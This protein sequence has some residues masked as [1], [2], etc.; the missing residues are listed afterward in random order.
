[1]KGRTSRYHGSSSQAGSSECNPKEY[2]TKAPHPIPYQ[3][4]KRNL[5]PSILGYFPKETK[6]LFEPFAGAAA[7]SIAA[8]LHRKAHSF[9]LND[10]NTPLM[11]LWMQII[12]SPETI[13]V[14][15]ME[16]WEKQSG[17]ER[18]YY[19]LVRDRFNNTKRVDY[20]LYLLLR[21]VKAAVRYNSDGQFNQSPDNR[22]RGM[23]PETL[24]QHVLAASKLLR[25]RTEVMSADY[26]EVLS[27]ATSEDLIYMDPPYQGVCGTRDQRYYGAFDTGSFQEALADLN[28][29]DISYILSYDGRSGKRVYGKPMPKSLGLTRIEIEAGRSSQATLLGESS[30]TI[31]SIYLSPA[32][33][34]R[35]GQISKGYL[36]AR[37]KQLTLVD[38]Q[39][40]S[41]LQSSSSD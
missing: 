38:W 19:D 20:L 8:A 16:L 30:I 27:S 31:E 28:A 32:L 22:R 4:S 12:D 25:G 24:R 1:M 39:S 41:Y 23:K 11:D 40:E 5:A 34:P 15:Y 9:V 14:A 3:G 35:I 26:R 10:I 21:C 6:R 2:V 29:R 13:A 17:K 36:T 18:E 37:P 7:V 33:C